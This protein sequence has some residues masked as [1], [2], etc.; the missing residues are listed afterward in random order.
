MHLFD[1][2]NQIKKYISTKAIME[3][4]YTVRLGIYAKRREHMIKVLKAIIK[5]LHNKFRFISGVIDGTIKVSNV[6]NKDV[7][8]QLESLKFDRK[9]ASYNYLTDLPIRKLTKEERDKLEAEY[10]SRQGELS[11]LEK[12]KS[13]TLWVRDLI[14]LYKFMYPNGSMEMSQ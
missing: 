4:W 10:N 7:I 2:N 12:T 11:A 9:D 5:D 8:A 14:A 13:E 3:E 1:A 6:P